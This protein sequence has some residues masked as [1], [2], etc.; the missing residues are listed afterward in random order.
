MGGV[1]RMSVYKRDYRAYSGAVTPLWSRLLVLV[2][3]GLDEVWSSKITVGF[4]VFAML[5]PIVAL[6]QIYVANN[7]TARLLFLKGGSHIFDINPSFFFRI[8]TTQCMLSL[9]LVSW[10]APRLITFDLADN[11]LPIL[12]S[13]PVSRFTYV[14]GKFIASFITLAS[15]T[16]FPCLLLF[17]FESYSAPSAWFMANLS[18]AWGIVVGIVIWISLLSILGLAM[19]SWV[20]WKIVA[21]G[22]IFAAILV[23]AGVGGIVMGVL[24]TKWGLLLNLPAVMFQLW[25]RLLGSP[26]IARPERTL[27]NAAIACALIAASLICAAMLNARIRAREV[28]RG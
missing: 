11:A 14:L 6:V 5:P 3:Y 24:R 8:L 21:T 12:L 22:S 7:P 20:K 9:A 23:P 16:L 2:R 13:H 18:V 27:P 19:S 15:I 25:Q 10:I 4:S 1:Q 28:V 26:E 17:V